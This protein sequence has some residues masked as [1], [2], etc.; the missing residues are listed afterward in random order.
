MIDRQN[1]EDIEEVGNSLIR[2][3][4]VC[5]LF[6]HLGGADVKIIRTDMV[7]AVFEAVA[8]LVGLIQSDVQALIDKESPNSINERKEQ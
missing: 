3:K 4:A 5:D 8:E 2:L 1:Y 7:A 6:G